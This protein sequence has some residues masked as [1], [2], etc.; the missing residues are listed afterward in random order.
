[1]LN[2]LLQV[3]IFYIGVNFPFFVTEV[4]H[5]IEV[6]HAVTCIYNNVIAMFLSIVLFALGTNDKDEIPGSNGE[7]ELASR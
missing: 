6:F 1:M 4:E 7:G 5:L 3:I 2:I